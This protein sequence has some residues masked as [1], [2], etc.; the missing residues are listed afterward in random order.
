M[1]AAHRSRT[2]FSKHRQRGEESSETLTGSICL[3]R[4][5]DRLREVQ[6]DQRAGEVHELLEAAV[7]VGGEP[8]A[9]TKLKEHEQTPCQRRQEAHR[10]PLPQKFD[11]NQRCYGESERKEL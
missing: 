1:V 4:P 9:E 8:Q 6:G 11:A 7:E 3:R 5:G 2:S 10:R